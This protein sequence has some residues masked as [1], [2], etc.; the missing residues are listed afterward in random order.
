MKK[1]I[2]IAL[3]FLAVLFAACN[4]PVEP[5]P[6]S[7]DYS[8]NYVGNY[9]G[10][11][12]FNDISMTMAGQTQTGIS[13]PID[14]IGMSIT[15]G[16]EANAIIATVTVDNET[17]QTAGTS[18]EE[19]ADFESIHLIIDKPDQGY[20]FELDLKMEGTKES[21][22]LNITGTFTGDGRFIFNEM[23]TV[24]DEVTGNLQ[25]KLVEQ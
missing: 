17:R 11:F 24:L 21:D 5:T 15:K 2:I 1:T 13:F 25:G 8:A 10:Q 14:S 12:L 19:K 3:S 7:V 9:V 20:K 22:T 16:S 18:M 23:E 6:P 4:K